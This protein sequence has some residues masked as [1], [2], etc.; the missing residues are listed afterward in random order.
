MIVEQKATVGLNKGALRRG[1]QTEQRD[2]K[3]TL[4]SQGIDK[5]LSARAR[6]AAGPPDSGKAG[7]PGT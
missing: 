6:V 4:E 5:K 1:S 3:P 7:N 2:N